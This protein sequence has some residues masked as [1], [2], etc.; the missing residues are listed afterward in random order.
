MHANAESDCFPLSYSQLNVDVCFTDEEWY[1]SFL[2]SKRDCLVVCSA[3]PSAA[4][5]THTADIL[6]SEG[7]LLLRHPNLG[8]VSTGY[9]AAIVYGI[10]HPQIAIEM[11]FG[12]KMHLAGGWNGQWMRKGETK[13]ARRM[14]RTKVKDDSFENTV[15]RVKK[16]EESE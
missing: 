11:G 9:I 15:A 14:V 13:G 7:D 4:A 1:S 12:R 8:L 10:A 3:C 5:L 2:S 6:F 16:E